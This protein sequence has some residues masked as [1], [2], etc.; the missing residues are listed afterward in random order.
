MKLPRYGPEDAALLDDSFSGHL[1][2]TAFVSGRA[3]DDV[4]F[5]DRVRGA[6]A[7]WLLK[8]ATMS[9]EGSMG[10]TRRYQLSFRTLETLA[11]DPPDVPVELTIS[12]KDPSFHWLDRVGGAWVGREVLLLVGH[13]RG[14]ERAILHF[15]GEPNQPELRARMLA[16]RA[17]QRV[18]LAAPAASVNK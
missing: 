5:E 17:Q 9:R 1:F 15:H 16:I 6:D 14:K 18:E 7:I 13:Y 12:G 10:D 8:V 4:H 2:E 11:G 3:G